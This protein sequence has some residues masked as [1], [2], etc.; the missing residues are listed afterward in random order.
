M[1]DDARTDAS[2]EPSSTIDG[3]P[4]TEGGTASFRSLHLW[5]IQSVRDVLLIA[6]VAGSVYVGY[7]MRTVTVPLLIA[8]ALAYLIE[9]L[10][11]RV[12]RWR[13]MSRP[14]A[15]GL[16]LSGLASLLAIAIAIVVPLAIGQTLSF[17]DS[18]RSGKYDG[19]VDRVLAEVPDEYREDARHWTDRIIHPSLKRAPEEATEHDA[20][21]V[22]QRAR[23]A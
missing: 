6:L 15:V 17:A 14:R 2:Q 11:V 9:P 20:D 18:L 5:Q 13:R 22:G 16:I 7:A 12:A 1:T 21:H 3:L 10:V 19:F 23:S 4:S 8:I